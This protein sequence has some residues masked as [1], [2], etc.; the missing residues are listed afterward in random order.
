MAV[1]CDAGLETESTGGRRLGRRFET[2]VGRGEAVLSA[3]L[4]EYIHC[5]RKVSGN[6]RHQDALLRCMHTAV[7]LAFSTI[8]PLVYPDA[9]SAAEDLHPVMRAVCALY[10]KHLRRSWFALENDRLD[11][12]YGIL[13][14]GEIKVG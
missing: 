6:S 13:A 5:F 3:L 12:L 7:E 14:N 9:V 8:V 1:M 11:A 4:E 10:L 2:V